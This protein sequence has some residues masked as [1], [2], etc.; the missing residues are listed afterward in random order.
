MMWILRYNYIYAVQCCTYQCYFLILEMAADKDERDGIHD[1]REHPLNPKLTGKHRDEWMDLNNIEGLDEMIRIS[2]CTLLNS[3]SIHSRRQY[4]QNYPHKRKLSVMY[5]CV[6]HYI[7]YRI[8][9]LHY[10]MKQKHTKEH[11][12]LRL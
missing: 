3:L 9:L 11:G 10:R 8:G 5:K 7:I 2:S 12:D 4:G 6:T 1:V